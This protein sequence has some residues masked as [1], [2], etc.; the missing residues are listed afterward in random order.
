M[1][2]MFKYC[3]E[4]EEAPKERRN[5]ADSGAE[6]TP[7]TSELRELRQGAAAILAGSVVLCF[8]APPVGVFGVV[9]ATGSKGGAKME[10]KQLMASE[11]QLINT[12]FQRNGIRAK[13]DKRQSVCVETGYISYA[14]TLA[15]DER[16]VK[17]EAMQRELSTVLGN[18]RRR[19]RLPGDVQ[20]I[21]VSFPRLALEL[22]HPQPYPCR[23]PQ[24]RE[25]RVY[26]TFEPEVRP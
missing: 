24:Q 20:V 10:N 11:A 1:A 22:P 17:V 14:L 21:P 8:L 12:M 5:S 2:Y 19:L 26:L 3:D 9:A 7:T 18:A 15:M 25:S 6:T 16:F 23:P 4:A 13:V